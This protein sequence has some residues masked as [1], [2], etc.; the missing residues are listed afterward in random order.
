MNGLSMEREIAEQPDALLRLQSNGIGPIRQVVS[1][2][3]DFQPRMVLF[4]GRG[5]SDHAALYAKYLIETQLQ[6]PAGMV[7]PSTF[8]IFGSR[9]SLMDVL[10]ITVS[11][12]G[13]SPDLV[14]STEI[15][16]ELGALTLAVT[17]SP[18]SKL[19]HASALSI[20]ILA[21]EEVAVAATKTYVNQLGAL[22]MLVDLLQGGDCEAMN[23]IPALARSVIE[24]ADYLPLIPSF[25]SCQR[26]IVTGRGFAFPTALEAALKLM[27]TSY[28]SAH[29]YSSADLM[30]GP[31]ALIEME[32][33]V[34][35]VVP[36]GVGG[37]AMRPV[38]E[39][40]LAEGASLTAVGNDLGL[41]G[42]AHRVSL[43]T[44]VSESVAPMLQILPLQQ[45]A[46]ALAVARGNDP[47]Q[48]RGLAKVTATR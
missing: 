18:E 3:R 8:T 20:D 37:E 15:A 16:R 28:V 43:P 21:G 19:A 31:L 45:F 47:D 25:L 23:P 12:S 14:E 2:I 42:L 38:L 35:A 41:S 36:W 11:Q 22:F 1:R 44:S 33:P 10:W 26:M 9:P 5:T 48:P 46:R 7:S 24:Q 13:E 30:H 40:L 17:N 34:V 32:R 6:L 27:E 39:R 4:A 29:A